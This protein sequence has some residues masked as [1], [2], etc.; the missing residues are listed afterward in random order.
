MDRIINMATKIMA[1]SNL[2]TIIPN[3][4]VSVPI[5]VSSIIYVCF[6]PVSAFN[7]VSIS[8]NVSFSGVVTDL[9]TE[10]SLISRISS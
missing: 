4:K 9:S 5:I 10:E 3:M 2:Q 6:S 7:P 8:D 1:M